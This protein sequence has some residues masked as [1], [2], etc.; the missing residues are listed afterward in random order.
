MFN[1][2]LNNSKQGPT[3]ITAIIQQIIKDKAAIKEDSAT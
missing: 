2:L 1:M 3:W